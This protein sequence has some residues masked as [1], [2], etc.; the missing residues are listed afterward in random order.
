MMNELAMET[1]INISQLFLVPASI[2]FAALG[3]ASTEPLKTGISFLGLSTSALWMAGLSQFVK[4]S[5]ELQWLP[6]A[7]VMLAS[8]F[9]LVWSVCL[10]AHVCSWYSQ[11]KP[12]K[13]T[14]RLAGIFIQAASKPE[15]NEVEE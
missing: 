13:T 12:K 11:C 14:I 8:L 9:V 15:L 2:F 1:I 10:I 5:S 3:I 4:C 6:T 7:C